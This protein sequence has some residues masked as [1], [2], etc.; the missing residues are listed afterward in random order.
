MAARAKRAEHPGWGIVIV[1][2]A[3]GLALVLAGWRKITGGVGP[4]IVESTADRSVA[5]PALYSWWGSEVLL[6]W[7]DFFSHL[8][9][10]GSFVL[11][12]A[13]F[14]GVLVRPVGWLIAFLMLNVYF[15]GPPNYRELVLLLGVC[16]IA[17]AVERAGRRI[18]L[19]ERIDPRMPGWVTWVRG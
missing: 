17:C 2:L 13:F 16:A 4:W 12:V 15:A 6:R 1:R 10:W 3:V 14:L 18:G 9:A 7:P 19:D 5:S 8:L 11:G